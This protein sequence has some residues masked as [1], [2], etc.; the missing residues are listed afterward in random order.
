MSDRL[1]ET[2][3]QLAITYFTESIEGL[4]VTQTTAAKSY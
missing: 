2:I 1:I 4:P 3:A